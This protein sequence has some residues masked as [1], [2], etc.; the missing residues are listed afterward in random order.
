LRTG[1]SGKRRQAFR[2][3]V[4]RRTA[5]GFGIEAAVHGARED[6]RDASP[7]RA[8]GVGPAQDLLVAVWIGFGAALGIGNAFRVRVVVG[9]AGAGQ[10]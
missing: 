5:R 9:A 6:G 3:L 4:H 7:V 2:E 10:V 8:D 1:V